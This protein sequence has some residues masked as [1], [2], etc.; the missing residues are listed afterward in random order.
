MERHHHGNCGPG[1]EHGSDSK[2]FENEY[3]KPSTS[4]RARQL[5]GN[6]GQATGG[7]ERRN[8]YGDMNATDDSLQ[9]NGNI[10]NSEDIREFLRGGSGRNR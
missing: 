8:R 7:V 3:G 5:N 1:E 6:M 10:Y 4:L 9:I 2:D